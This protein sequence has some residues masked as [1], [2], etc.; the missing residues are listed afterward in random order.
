MNLGAIAR[1][2]YQNLAILLAAIGLL[3]AP[4][5]ALA[6]DE[7]APVEATESLAPEAI[8]PA[9][10]YYGPDMIKG[11]PTPFEEDALASMTF[12]EQF[13][14]N[15]DYALWMHDAILMPIIVVISFFVLFL[16]LWVVARYR[17]KA[18]PVA[19]K[20]SHNTLI[21]VVW[22]VIPV[23]ILVV[24]AVPSISL[25]A[26]QYETP[27]ADAITIKANGYQWYWGYEYLDN[28][29]FEVISNMKDE[30]ASLDAGEPF[31][32]AVDNR[33]VVPVGV[34]IRL[35]T[36]GKDVI[37]AFGIP[38]LWFKLDAVP[39]RI[40]EK[41]LVIDEP[42]IYYG[43]CMELCGARHG[44]MPIAIEAR[45][46][47]EFEEWVRTQPGGTVASDVVAEAEVVEDAEAEVAE[48]VAEELV[49]DAAPAV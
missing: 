7:V 11:Q 44:Y 13:T 12:Q 45:P 27:P 31:Q 49:E 40:N 24:I 30:S 37:H 15:G 43:Q 42:G 16:L 22:T 35:Q 10:E 23:I 32:L 17:K 8:T 4:Q 18:N 33:M 1:K 39:G 26:K 25:L 46:V 21:E 14:A 41:M 6:Q 38:S 36:F 9:F 47:E 3:A 5:V 29:G 19:S 48:D 20:T 2:T 34:P 28:G